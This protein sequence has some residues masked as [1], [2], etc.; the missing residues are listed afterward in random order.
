MPRLRHIENTGTGRFVTFSCY[1]RH[2]YLSDSASRQ[3]L[4]DELAFL[5]TEHQIK[6][7]GYVIM[8]EHVHLV[9]DPPD[10]C[11]LGVLIGQMKARSAR[12]TLSHLQEKGGRSL[13][14]ADGKPAVWQRRCYDHNC[15]T[16]DIVVE[17]I[18]YCHNNPVSRGLVSKPEDW[19]WSSYRWYH[20]RR[21]SEFE[22]DGVEL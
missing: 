21:E 2:R 14:R 8:P 3:A 4:L 19:P 5:R 15:R 10:G 18:R 20:G 11:R 16:M 6:I 1:R 9:L 12:R 7:L 22:I 13:K 17:K